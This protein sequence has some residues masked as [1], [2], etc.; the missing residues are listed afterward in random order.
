[1]HAYKN[2]IKK[3]RIKEKGRWNFIRIYLGSIWFMCALVGS[4]AQASDT[5]SCDFLIRFYKIRLWHKKV[6]R[7]AATLFFF[8]SFLLLHFFLRT[9]L[10]CIRLPFVVPK[11]ERK[12]NS[13]RMP[14]LCSLIIEYIKLS[15]PNWFIPFIFLTPRFDAILYV[16][17]CICI[18]IFF[19]YHASFIFVVLYTV[20][21]SGFVCIR[22]DLWY[23]VSESM[24][25][26]E[27]IHFSVLIVS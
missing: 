20:R 25:N 2:N 19:F 3:K 26:A 12:K 6:G 27:D 1:M 23:W 4:I 8:L 18:C 14:V 17:I 15:T 22:Q 9:D 7:C 11:K 21:A 24:H 5:T 16:C 13:L 10:L